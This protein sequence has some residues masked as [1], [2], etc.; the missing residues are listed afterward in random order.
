MS[1]VKSL[2]VTSLCAFLVHD[3]EQIKVD[4]KSGYEQMGVFFSTTTV[5]NKI[6]D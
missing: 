3:H 4:C 6:H 5:H 2:F 1:T